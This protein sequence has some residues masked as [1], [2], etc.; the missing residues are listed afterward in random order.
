MVTLPSIRNEDATEYNQYNERLEHLVYF[1]RKNSEPEMELI[2]NKR[3]YNI[4][5][6]NTAD[7]YRLDSNVTVVGNTAGDIG[8]FVTLTIT[9]TEDQYNLTRSND[10]LVTPDYSINYGESVSVG[11]YGAPLAGQFQIVIITDVALTLDELATDALV[12]EPLI[13]Y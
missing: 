3:V 6:T 10:V 7:P 8:D 9:A 5:N 1:Y 2:S 12:L 11:T 13:L 4:T